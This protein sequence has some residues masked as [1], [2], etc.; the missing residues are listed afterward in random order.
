MDTFRYD[1]TRNL[2]VR[3]ATSTVVFSPD[4]QSWRTESSRLNGQ[5][6]HI[7]HYYPRIDRVFRLSHPSIETIVIVR[8]GVTD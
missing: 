2:H 8:H 3:C 4:F 7:R 6:I 5:S 1:R